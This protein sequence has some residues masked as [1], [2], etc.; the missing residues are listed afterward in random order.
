MITAAWHVYNDLAQKKA[1]SLVEMLPCDSLRIA[2]L[3]AQEEMD[4]G[5]AQLV[6]PVLGQE[7]LS[8]EGVSRLIKDGIPPVPGNIELSLDEG[9]VLAIVDTD[10]AIV[11]Y[12]IQEGI[13]PPEG[14]FSSWIT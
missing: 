11:Y 3:V 4:A 10:S 12:R 5:K 9:V 14:P 8:L 6:V 1:W 13:V 7:R 2:Y